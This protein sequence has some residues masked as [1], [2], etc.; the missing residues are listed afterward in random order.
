MNA[1]ARFLLLIL[2][3]TGAPLASA[4][5]LSQPVMLVAK[6]ELLHPLYSRSVLVVKPFTSSQHIG[7]ILNRPTE[8]TLGKMFPEHGPSQKVVNPVYL[9][10][11]VD[12]Q[13][14][15]ALV[16]RAENPGGTGFEVVPGL[17]AV[18]DARTVDR[19][20]ENEADQ[21]RFLVGMVVWRPGELA[22]EIEQGA[23]HVRPVDAE[24]AMREPSGLWES[25]ER[26]SRA[27]RT[28]FV[29]P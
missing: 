11:P 1:L 24:T 13:M 29:V 26:E 22:M 28:R 10:G 7:F 2:F 4:A 18:F 23:W 16:E 19:I 5:D 14:M 9:G 25:L 12:A 15:F 17:F 3:I 20:I 27:V 21:A 6:R 8:L